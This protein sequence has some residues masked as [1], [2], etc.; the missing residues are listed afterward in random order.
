MVRE[1]PFVSHA[2]ITIEV[3]NDIRG[4]AD[5]GDVHPAPFNDIPG[6]VRKEA[7]ASASLLEFVAGPLVD[8]DVEIE[9]SKKQGSC[10]SAQ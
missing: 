5:A 3:A 4:R 10:E 9:I 8:R 2:A 7:E 6:S 1:V